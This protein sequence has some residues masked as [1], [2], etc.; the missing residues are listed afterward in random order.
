MSADRLRERLDAG[1]VAYGIITGWA[2]PDVVE[3]AGACGFDFIFIDAEHGALDIRTCGDLLR[4][5]TCGG[6]TA[7]IRVPYADSRGVYTYL[8]AGANGLIF[9][10]VRNAADARAAV[11]ACL[12]P[13]AGLRGALSSSRAARYGTAY[14]KPEDYY[15]SANDAMWVLPLI[16]DVEA[17]DALDEIVAVPGVRG[18][19]IGP[20]DLGLSRV[21]THKTDGPTVEALL[22]RAIERGVRAG[23]V[24]GTVAGTP[25]AAATLAKKGVRMI[26]AGASGLLIGAYKGFLQGVP[27]KAGA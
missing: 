24:V 17:V 20:G 18:F 26:C 3:A 14:S 6:L 2:D 5:A 9:P 8:D 1:E 10:H 25:A 19:F 21:A 11:N 12:Y 7:I 23:K 13:P 22:D 15:R 4:A 27:R 16:E